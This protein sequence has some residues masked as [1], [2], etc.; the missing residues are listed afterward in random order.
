MVEGEDGDGNGVGD[1]QADGSDTC[2]CG[3]GD[4]ASQG[5]KSEDE[6]EGAGEPDCREGWSAKGLVLVL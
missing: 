2:C 6:R 5:G 3:K 1:V 4:G